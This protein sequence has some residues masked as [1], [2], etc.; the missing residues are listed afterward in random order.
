[1]RARWLKPEFFTDKKVASLGPVDALVF[2][3]LWCMADDGGTALADADLVKAQM[4]YRWSAVGVPE[5]TGALRNL[6]VCGMIVVYTVGDDQFAAI[7]SWDKHQQVHKPSKFRHPK[8]PQGVTPAVPESP[9]TTPAPLHA[10][11]PPR[12]LDTKTPRHLDTQ[13]P[14]TDPPAP[15][16]RVSW[17]TPYCV[18]WK[19]QYGGDM[20]IGP[21]TKPLAALRSEH[22]E[23]VVLGRWRNYLAATGAQYANAARFAQTFGQ[24]DHNGAGMRPPPRLTKQEIGRQTLQDAIARRAAEAANHG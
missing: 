7:R 6:S 18:A 22:D 21:A 11:P 23:A 5:I 20:A 2:Q 12:H 19:L 13:T 16:A 1:M 17:L 14:N 10:S 15:S 4:F 24:W 8:Q 3:A 9:G